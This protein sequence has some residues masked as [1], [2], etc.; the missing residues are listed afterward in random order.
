MDVKDEPLVLKLTFY[1]TLSMSCNTSASL[2]LSKCGSDINLPNRCV[3]R[4]GF[5]AYKCQILDMTNQWGNFN[6]VLID[7]KTKKNHSDLID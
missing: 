2:S 6:P 7:F 3:E 5:P 1:V 4:T